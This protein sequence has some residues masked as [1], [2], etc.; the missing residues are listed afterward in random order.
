MTQTEIFKAFS[1]LPPKQRLVIAKKI[2][3]QMSDELF[4]DLDAY[5]PNIEM[6]D[7]EIMKEVKAVRNAK[8]KKN[9]I[10]S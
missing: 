4:A 10:D 3:D 5:L 7:T 1:V 9:Q 8:A 2:Q 6:S